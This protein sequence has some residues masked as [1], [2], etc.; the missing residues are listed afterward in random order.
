MS[1][2]DWDA[3][4]ADFLAWCRKRHRLAPRHPVFRR[5]RWFQGRPIRGTEDLAWFRPDGQAMT[6][7]DWENGYARSVGVLLNGAAIATPDAYGGRIVDDSFFVMFNASELDLTWTCP[8]TAGQRPWMVELDTGLSSHAERTVV[9][10]RPTC[11]TVAERSMLRPAGR[12][13]PAT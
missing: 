7:D 12:P 8:T 1:W 5:R 11:S 9:G 10:A 13:G 2:F 3:V 6:D 4:D